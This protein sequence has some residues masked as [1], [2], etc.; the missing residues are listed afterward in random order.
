MDLGGIDI[1]FDAYTEYL[2]VLG[3]FGKVL[4][5]QQCKFFESYADIW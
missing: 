2:R 5:Y 4:E 1:A 3:Y